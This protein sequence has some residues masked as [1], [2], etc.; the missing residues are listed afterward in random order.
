MAIV[1]VI[2]PV[3]ILVLAGYLA[4]HF[5]VLR[6]GDVEGLSRFVFNIALPV[7][8][9][10]SVATI[11]LP[12]EMDWIFL[13]AYYLVVVVIYGLGM[14]LSRRW[15]SAPPPEQSIFGMGA[16]YSNLMLVGLP[17]I[18]AGLGDEALLPLFLLVSV[19]SAILFFM[20]SV[21][22]E[23]GGGNGRSPR[24]IARQTA[25][26][27]GRNP[28]IIGLAL[29]FLVNVLA[30]PLPAALVS[31][32]DLVGEATL[33]CSLFVLG[34]A[35]TTYKIAGHFS[36]AGLIIALKLALQPI[37]VWL[38]V[39]HVFTVD[40]LWGTVAVMAAGM[41][42]GVSAYIYAQNYHLGTAALSTAVL[43][44]TIL[45]V[46]SQSLWLLLLT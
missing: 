42:V 38:L 10:E 39:F 1:N 7:L 31:A 46:F 45:A 44:S 28:I 35:L 13:F 5:G 29:G 11:T 21:L 19:H 32:L 6:T 14:W 20:T 12:E 25:R 24:Q 23:R 16:S 37:L 17:V 33:S 3:F 40:P 26:G 41:P 4:A 2:V 15:F 18:S 43:L 22:V 30:V 27:L 9:F 34:G 8:L 36:E